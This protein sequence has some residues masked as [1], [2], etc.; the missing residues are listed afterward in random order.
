MNLVKQ[1]KIKWKSSAESFMFLLAEAEIVDE[2]PEEVEERSI[3]IC[4]LNKITR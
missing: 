1:V 3:H 2:T 4:D